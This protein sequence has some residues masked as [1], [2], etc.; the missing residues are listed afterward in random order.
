MGNQPVD[1]KE[2]VVTT[3]RSEKNAS[4][5]QDDTGKLVGW[6]HPYLT[7]QE[8]IYSSTYSKWD[9]SGYIAITYALQISKSELDLFNSIQIHLR[10]VSTAKVDTLF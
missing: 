10:K 8:V 1:V 6:A 3:L 5:S 9:W 7:L 4:E 2:F